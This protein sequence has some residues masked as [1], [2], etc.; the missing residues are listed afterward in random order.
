[1]SGSRYGIAAIACLNFVGCGTA[2]NLET[3]RVPFGGVASDIRQLM[4][5]RQAEDVVGIGPPLMAIDA[6]ISLVADTAT[7][8]ITL[9]AAT[10]RYIQAAQKDAKERERQRPVTKLPPQDEPDLSNDGPA[11]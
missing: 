6:P 7:L 4:H 9:C 1:M 2:K 8:P 3:D 10:S 5:G 11:E